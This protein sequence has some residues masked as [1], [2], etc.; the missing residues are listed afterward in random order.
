MLPSIKSI[1]VHELFERLNNDAPL[2]IDIRAPWEIKKAHLDFAH[3]VAPEDLL[4][5][6]QRKNQEKNYDFAILCHYGIR[7]TIAVQFLTQKG[8][9]ALNITGGIHAWSC[10]INSVI[11]QY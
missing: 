3:L 2:V 11:P 8:F 5:F 7:S 1:T 6:C 10:H 9:N 4:D